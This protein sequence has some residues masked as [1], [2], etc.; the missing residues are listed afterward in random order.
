MRQPCGRSQSGASARHAVGVCVGKKFDIRC[1]VHMPVVGVVGHKG[2]DAALHERE[3][4]LPVAAIPLVNPSGS[5]RLAAVVR[6]R[7]G[8][9]VVACRKYGCDYAL[10]GAFEVGVHLRGNLHEEWPVRPRDVAVPTR[11]HGLREVV[12]IHATRGSYTH[13]SSH[14][15]R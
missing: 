10:Q 15:T 7:E 3:Q 14:V 8:H 9:D 6:Q 2:R 11:Q 12:Y 4:L 13:R 1:D 5:V